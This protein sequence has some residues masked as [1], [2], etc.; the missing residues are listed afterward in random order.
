MRHSN[1]TATCTIDN[2]L[3]LDKYISLMTTA[4][5]ISKKRS[6]KDSEAKPSGKPQPG[7]KNVGLEPAISYYD[8]ED[9]D[10]TGK[11]E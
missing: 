6:V 4:K 7:D 8:I 2:R 1:I 11:G 9:G 3:V 10:E 5:T